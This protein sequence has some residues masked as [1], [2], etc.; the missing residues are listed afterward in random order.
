[1]GLLD[2]KASAARKPVAP[3]RAAPVP[4]RALVAP[5]PLPFLV[6]EPPAPPPPPAEPPR[7]RD[8]EPDP[9]RVGLVQFEPGKPFLHY[10]MVCGA[11][12]AWGFDVFLLKGRTGRWYC[13]AHRP[14]S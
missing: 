11:W 7:A 13:S 6:D 14:Q 1:M 8:D 4:A 10:C 5:E 9:S 3:V 12:G 2:A